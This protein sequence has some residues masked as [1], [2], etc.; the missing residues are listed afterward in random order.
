[1]ILGQSAARP[2]AASPKKASPPAKPVRFESE[3]GQPPAGVREEM[4]RRHETPFRFH[5]WAH[6][7]IN[8]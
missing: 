6:A 3:A 1:M 4:R 7:G 5:G 8:D 2:A